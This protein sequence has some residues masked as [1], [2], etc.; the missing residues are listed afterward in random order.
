MNLHL[1]KDRALHKVFFMILDMITF[2]SST[3]HNPF[4]I[5]VPFSQ[6]VQKLA[7]HIKLALKSNESFD[8]NPSKEF[9]YHRTTLLMHLL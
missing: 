7:L 9:I 1:E 6:I 4:L 3:Q 2:K 5:S 8:M